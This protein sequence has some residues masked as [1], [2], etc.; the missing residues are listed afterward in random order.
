MKLESLFFPFN[1]K[2][3]QANIVL[4]QRNCNSLLLTFIFEE[5]IEYTKLA[6][7]ISIFTE[8]RYHAEIMEV[9]QKNYTKY[10]E[11]GMVF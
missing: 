2:L 4:K 8:E 6:I 9:S 10:L 5:Q 11:K 3:P 7:N 1:L